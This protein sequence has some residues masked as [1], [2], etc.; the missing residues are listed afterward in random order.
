MS[1]YILKS[2]PKTSEHDEKI[3]FLEYSVEADNLDGFS[4]LHK[5]V[6]ADS[7]TE[8]IECAKK[9]VV[10]SKRKR[11]KRFC[12]VTLSDPRGGQLLFMRKKEIDLL[13]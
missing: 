9:F 10:K 5:L 11:K 1:A 8:A 12:D 6:L 13:K 4:C 7:P 2:L 3:Y